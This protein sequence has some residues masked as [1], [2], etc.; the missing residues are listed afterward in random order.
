MASDGINFGV[1][2]AWRLNLQKHSQ[3]ILDDLLP[4][5]FFAETVDS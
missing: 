2:E 5:L 3:G 1:T 4:N